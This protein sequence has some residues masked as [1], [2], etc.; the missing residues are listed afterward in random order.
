[1][2]QFTRPTDLEEIEDEY[3]LIP[4]GDYPVKITGSGVKT[5][6]AGHDAIEIECTIE[7]GKNTGRKVWNMFNIN[8]PS[9][10]AKAIANSQLNKLE[11]SIGIEGFNDTDE[12]LGK[13][14]VAEIVVNGEYNNIKSY[15]PLNGHPSRAAAL[16][17]AST[18][19]E[20]ASIPDEDDG[21]PF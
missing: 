9:A 21:F 1:M 20:L 15:K 12:L 3:Q 17:Q 8:N 16:P 4:P 14:F 19:E 7:D 5:T 10:K 2:A 6:K 11:K 18:P 13:R